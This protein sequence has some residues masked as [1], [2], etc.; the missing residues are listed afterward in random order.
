MYDEF[1]TLFADSVKAALSGNRRIKAV[2]FTGLALAGC[3]IAIG[4]I[5]GPLDFH[6]NVL[7][8][9][10]VAL[11]IISAIIIFGLGIYKRALESTNREK[12][13]KEAE[14][15]ARA[16]PN[17][18]QAAWDLA[19]VKLESYLNRNLKQVQWIF[20]VT[21]LVMT[22]GFIIIG[23]GV[24]RVYQSPENFRPSVV[25][26]VSG[27]LVEFIAATFL[28]IYKSTME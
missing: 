28:L 7:Q 20:A 6:K 26:T 25:V 13:L 12:I 19:R 16:H 11:G 14:E 22:A 27:I 4:I 2:F 15:H 24:Y 23:Y 1:F 10:A 8:P 21:L 5:S 9:I 18:P 3:A 17:E